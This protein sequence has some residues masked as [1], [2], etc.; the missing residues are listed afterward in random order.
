MKI[1][2]S[3]QKKT[4]ITTCVYYGLLF[5][6]LGLVCV[7]P[8]LI[9]DDFEFADLALTNPRDLISYVLYYGNGRLMGNLTGIFLIN[10]PI[11][12]GLV[13]AV[14][15]CGI[16]WLLPRVSTVSPKNRLFLAAIVPLLVLGVNPDIAG[17]VLMWTSGWA[18]FIPPILIG[19]LCLYVI[20]SMNRF[21]FKA[22]TLIVV[23]GFVGQLYVEHA[24]AI[25]IL[26]ALCLL[27][28]YHK[29]G[30]KI[31]ARYSLCWLA[32]GICGAA[33]MFAIPKIFFLEVNRSAGYRTFHISDFVSH[34]YGALLF[35]IS[36]FEQCIALLSV[37]SLFGFLVNKGRSTLSLLK[38][39][40]YLLIPVLLGIYPYLNISWSI[41]ALAKHGLTLIYLTLLLIDI[42]LMKDK[43]KKLAVLWLCILAIIA[44][45]P[46]LVITP[47][48]E[49]C[50]HLSYILLCIAALI[51]VESCIESDDSIRTKLLQCASL[52]GTAAVC[53]ILAVSMVK[54]H[55]YDNIRDSYIRQQIAAGETEVVIF[56]LPTRYTFNTY[57][58]DLYYYDQ[59]PRDV[60]FEIIDLDTW[61]QTYYQGS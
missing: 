18:N 45:A 29:R 31:Q 55:H 8:P 14:T 47:F 57:L 41:L 32:A 51:C 59:K 56:D 43:S 12:C 23:L 52:I 27:V 50:M 39:T 54:I 60:S 2:C 34:I 5:I 24:T 28:Y 7:N 17:Q 49:R 42:L 53:V 37:F 22:A 20:Q 1:K 21:S 36:T 10:Y 44:T 4:E 33:L 9:S 48:G 3:V 46:F 35:S 16:I 25:Q 30:H 11:L 19:L 40:V 6:F 38:K 61:M 26:A 58:L 13:K 15:F